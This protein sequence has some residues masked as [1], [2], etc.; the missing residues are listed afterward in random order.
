MF[1]SRDEREKYEA[2]RALG[3][4]P[5]LLRVGWAGLSTSESGRVGGLVSAKRRKN[6]KEN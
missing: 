1:L 6:A 5:K 4:M 2:A 3:L